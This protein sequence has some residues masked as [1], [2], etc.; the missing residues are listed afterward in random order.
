MR[1]SILVF[2]AVAVALV[3]AGSDAGTVRDPGKVSLSTSTPRSKRTITSCIK[4]RAIS[5]RSS[6]A[7]GVMRQRGLLGALHMQVKSTQAPRSKNYLN[8]K[9]GEV[10]EGSDDKKPAKK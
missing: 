8:A 3:P 7:V 2:T 10:E 5:V 4:A 9:A 1:L 6:L